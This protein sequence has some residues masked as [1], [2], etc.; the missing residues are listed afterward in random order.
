MVFKAINK[1]ILPRDMKHLI[2]S[3]IDSRPAIYKLIDNEIAHAKAGKPAYM[4]LKMNSLADEEL[5]AKTI[6]GGQSRGE[7]SIDHQGDVLPGAGC[8]GCERKHQCD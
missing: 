1:G 5:I 8:K 7:D 3:P 2:V 6:P 4:I